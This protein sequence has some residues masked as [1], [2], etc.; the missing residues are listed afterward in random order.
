[1]VLVDLQSGGNAEG[2]DAGSDH[3]RALESFRL[4]CGEAD[5]DALRR[6]LE[7]ALEGGDGDLSSI[8]L[9]A[10]ADK[11]HRSVGFGSRSRGSDRSW[12]IRVCHCSVIHCFCAGGARVHQEE[13]QVPD[14]G[15]C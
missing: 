7:R 6:F 12:M 10:D 11:A 1:V 14:H 4:L 2:G 13:F 8:I 9:S 3:S 5:H 15:Y